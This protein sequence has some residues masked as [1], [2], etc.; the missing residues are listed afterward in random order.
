MV[1]IIHGWPQPVGE[2]DLIYQY[3]RQKGYRVFCPYLFKMKKCFSLLEVK[4]ELVTCLGG[5]KPEVIV[6]ISVGG[7]IMPSLAMDYPK[8]KLVFV[9]T[10]TCF[11]PDNWLAKYGVRWCNKGVIR[12]IKRVGERWLL[13]FY[14]IVNPNRCWN[15][16]E[17]QPDG[18]LK[19]NLAKTLALSEERIAE[20]IDTVGKIDN[21]EILKT[22]KN[23]AIIFSGDKDMV[24]P[25][26]HGRK[27]ASLMRNS[28]L[29][30][31]S[32][33]HYNL[34]GEEMFG[35]LDGFL[36]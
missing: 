12:I 27:I 19:D 15:D 31:L 28:Q 3:F 32:G 2:K 25:A 10:G 18:M 34:I 9:A 16:K 11:A 5:K 8:A 17:S 23:K 29:K 1:L 24:M 20:I 4:R 7:L 35:T 22:L 36:D 6:G 21:R 14:R 30:I 26:E 33:K 13:R